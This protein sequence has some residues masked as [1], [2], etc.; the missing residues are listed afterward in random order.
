AICTGGPRGVGEKVPLAPLVK[1]WELCQKLKGIFTQDEM[2]TALLSFPSQ[3]K[4]VSYDGDFG[5]HVYQDPRLESAVRLIS[6]AANWDRTR[7]SEVYNSLPEEK[8]R[9]FAKDKDGIGAGDAIEPFDLISNMTTGLIMSRH[10]GKD[11]TTNLELNKIQISK[12]SQK[13]LSRLFRMFDRDADHITRNP[14]LS[15]LRTDGNLTVFCANGFFETEESQGVTKSGY[16][17][18]WQK[19]LTGTDLVEAWSPFFDLERL[20]TE[21]VMAFPF[22]CN[23]NSYRFALRNR[24][25]EEIPEP[26]ALNFSAASELNALMTISLVSEIDR[27]AIEK[28]RF[29]I[30]KLGGWK[31]EEDLKEVETKKV[32]REEFEKTDAYIPVMHA[33]DVN[34]FNIGT[35][36]SLSLRLSRRVKDDQGRS[37]TLRL[38]VLFPLGSSQMSSLVMG[39]AELA[40]ILDARYRTKRS[41]LF[42]MNNSCGS[43]KTLP[44]WALVYRKAFELRKA[45]GEVR[46]I[47]Q[48]TDFPHIIGSVFFDLVG[49][50]DFRACGVPV[51]VPG[52]ADRRK[53]RG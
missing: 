2:R 18:S 32:F 7:F 51:E 39:P 11:V 41:P 8:K 16:G 27:S 28:G 17:T 5:Y 40:E 37:R 31:I 12:L 24:P 42:L 47:S 21:K 1:S 23:T 10:Y 15:L 53:V 14:S 20:R 6:V 48:V 22:I 3:P 49:G 30:S 45:R 38:T 43:E 4:K 13:A 35:G 44:A 9:I 25:V 36:R 46:S 33:M 26:A 50:A 52:N 19:S 34:Y 29:L